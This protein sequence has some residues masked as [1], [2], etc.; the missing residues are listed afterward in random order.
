[1]RVCTS[2]ALPLLISPFHLSSTNE[3][4]TRAQPRRRVWGWPYRH[5]KEANSSPTFTPLP[6]PLYIEEHRSL[7]CGFSSLLPLSGD[8]REWGFCFTDKLTSNN[9]AVQAKIKTLLK[10]DKS[11]DAKW[12][13]WCLQGDSCFFFCPLPSP[14]LLFEYFWRTQVLGDE[15]K[16]P[17][18]CILTPSA[19]DQPVPCRAENIWA[20]A[21]LDEGFGHPQL[22][23]F[24]PFIS[25]S[26]PHKVINSP[27]HIHLYS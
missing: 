23:S 9:P 6:L 1:M 26:W 13:V 21:L 24:F 3:P 7:S 11:L 15:A 18:S 25:I 20:M 4:R 14:L 16:S 5:G 19:S 8:E 2:A 10:A 22:A 27:D 12:P 17:Q